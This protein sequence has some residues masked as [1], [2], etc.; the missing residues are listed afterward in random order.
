VKQAPVSDAA[1]VAARKKNQDKKFYRKQGEA[2]RK[3]RDASIAEK[4]IMTIPTDAE[5]G[6]AEGEAAKVR[7]I[8][9]DLLDAT[10]AEDRGRVTKAPESVSA[11]TD[12]R[13]AADIVGKEAVE[14]K[15]R[16]VPPGPRDLETEHGGGKQRGTIADIVGQDADL[17]DARNEDIRRASSK[18]RATA[19]ARNATPE[20]EA[21]LEKAID[22]EY[23]RSLEVYFD[24]VEADTRP[25]NQ[26]GPRKPDARP[27]I[28]DSMIDAQAELTKARGSAMPPAPADRTTVDQKIAVV[29]ERMKPGGDAVYKGQESIDMLEGLRD[30]KPAKV[31]A[32]HSTMVLPPAKDMVTEQEASSKRGL[33]SARGE[34]AAAGQRAAAAKAATGAAGPAA[35]PRM[36]PRIVTTETGEAKALQG[37]QAGIPAATP[38][39]EHGV[40]K[41]AQPKTMAQL[42]TGR[43]A[44]WGRSAY[45][46]QI[47]RL[48]SPMLDVAGEKAKATGKA[49]ARVKTAGLAAKGLG[50]A[51]LAFTALGAGEAYAGEPDPK[52]RLGKAG[53]QFKEGLPGTVEDIA[54]F[55]AADVGVTKVI[56]GLASR[57]ATF[58]GANAT[59]AAFAKGASRLIGRGFL[60]GYIGY[61]ALPYTG[62]KLAEL[63][64]TGNEA[65]KSA[66]AASKEKKGSEAKYGTVELATKTR[67]AKE[68]AKRKKGK[69]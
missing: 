63:A 67:H 19:A 30:Q 22:A 14:A 26:A 38:A 31:K 54:K 52:K 20:M 23:D 10:L 59:K 17:R 51:A 62:K 55:T 2:R 57:A 33:T 21:N 29:R 8:Q 44:D 42:W 39:V 49:A 35:V 69:K 48:T 6:S 53:E 46:A 25:K 18:A 41:G 1:V 37:K 68:A 50:V 24:D 36:G 13:T 32:P 11:A 64:W 16:V 47:K 45:Q 15:V 4:G 43:M 40:V 9:N 34:G 3:A 60:A 58:L 27:R 61:H 28:M 66:S 56:P 12:K 7:K 5:A 65:R